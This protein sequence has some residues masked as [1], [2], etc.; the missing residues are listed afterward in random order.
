MIAEVVHI[1]QLSSLS[2]IVQA[3]TISVVPAGAHGVLQMAQVAMQQGVT[4]PS[5]LGSLC[6]SVQPMFGSVADAFLR[7]DRC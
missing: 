5:P 1:T 6:S 4:P 7:G 3:T 2:V